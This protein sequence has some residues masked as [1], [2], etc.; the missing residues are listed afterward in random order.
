MC[1]ELY[2]SVYRVF[3][4]FLLFCVVALITTIADIF[5][6]VVLLI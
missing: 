5:F 6:F 4:R 2:A 3:I 1:E